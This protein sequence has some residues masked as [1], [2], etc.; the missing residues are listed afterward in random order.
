MIL[1]D[2]EVVVNDTGMGLGKDP[3]MTA[4]KLITLTKSFIIL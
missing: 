2:F 1:A 4:Q 3:S